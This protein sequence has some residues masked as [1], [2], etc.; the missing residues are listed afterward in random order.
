MLTNGHS[1]MIEEGMRLFGQL[2]VGVGTNPDK[3]SMFTVAE[4]V[5]MIRE[6]FPTVEVVSFSNE[7]TVEYCLKRQDIPYI[8]RGIRSEKDYE[9]ERM[10]RHVNGDIE[11]SITTV[12]LIPP[13]NLAEVSSSMVKGMIGF[14]GW[15]RVIERYV[16]ALVYKKI[17]EKEK[18]KIC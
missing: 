10:M 4:R 2:V 9:A 3:K 8:L 13:R 18:A 1:W 17:L 15:V 16:P 7:F 6:C 14:R 5:E 12:F 11:N